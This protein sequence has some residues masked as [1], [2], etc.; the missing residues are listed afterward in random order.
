MSAIIVGLIACGGSAELAP[1]DVQ[2]RG[3]EVTQ[4]EAPLV[5]EAQETGGVTLY[6]H[7][8]EDHDD[9]ALTGVPSIRNGCLWVGEHVV[10]WHQS[11]LVEAQALAAE[12]QSSATT[13][14]VS[15]GGGEALA[16]ATGTSTV[17]NDCGTDLVWVGS[18]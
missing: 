13:N 6:F 11:R 4:Q 14:D 16:T 8:A 2:A 18:P 10:I 5:V 15:V 1:D 17:R 9:A 12:L 7:E 3:S